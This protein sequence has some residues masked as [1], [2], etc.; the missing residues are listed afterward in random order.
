LIDLLT[1]MVEHPNRALESD[2]QETANQVLA[3]I[4]SVRAIHALVKE[5]AQHPNKTL[6]DDCRR[7]AAKALEDWRRSATVFG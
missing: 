1:Q 2:W 5:L 3:S 7:R 6:E 4:E